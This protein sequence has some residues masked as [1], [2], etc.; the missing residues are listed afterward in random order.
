MIGLRTQLTP[1]HGTMPGPRLMAVCTAAI[2][3]ALPSGSGQRP[4]R[5]LPRYLSPARP[6]VCPL[7]E[8]LA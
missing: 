6:A 8:S 7:T 4:I 5:A 3:P 2:R 1:M